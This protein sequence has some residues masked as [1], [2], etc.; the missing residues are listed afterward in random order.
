MPLV[1]ELRAAW[2]PSQSRSLGAAQ[3]FFWIQSW[4][5]L[6][7]LACAFFLHRKWVIFICSKYSLKTVFRASKR[8]WQGLTGLT[9]CT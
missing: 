6:A 8:L 2:T 1:C 7:Q 9:Q 5:I 4:N 3:T